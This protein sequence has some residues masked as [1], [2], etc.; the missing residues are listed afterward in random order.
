MVGCYWDIV[1]PVHNSVSPQVAE[2]LL[3]GKSVSLLLMLDIIHVILSTWYLIDSDMYFEIT[4]G[5]PLMAYLARPFI[6]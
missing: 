2:L 1:I 5:F 6:G 3:C 4:V